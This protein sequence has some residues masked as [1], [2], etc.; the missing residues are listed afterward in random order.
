[1]PDLQKE[2]EKKKKKVYLSQN[3]IPFP[4]AIKTKVT[5][6]IRQKLSWLICFHPPY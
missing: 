1:M 4:N 2:K 6:L 5:C 3:M